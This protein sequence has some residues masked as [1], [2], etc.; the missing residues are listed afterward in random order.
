MSFILE[1]MDLEIVDLKDRALKIF[2]R[3]MQFWL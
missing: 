1:E 3:S 2:R